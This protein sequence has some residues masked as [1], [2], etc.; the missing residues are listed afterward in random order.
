[1]LDLPRLTCNPPNHP[2]FPYYPPGHSGFKRGL[3]ELATPSN[4]R[5]KDKDQEE[6]DGSVMIEQGDAEEAILIEHDAELYSWIVL[7]PEDIDGDSDD[8]TYG[9]VNSP[10]PSIS[11]SV[12]DLGIPGSTAAAG[13]EGYPVQSQQLHA[14]R[15]LAEDDA[16][17]IELPGSE[18]GSEDESYVVPAASGSPWSMD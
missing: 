7:A 13:F 10:S 17:Y 14:R 8:G 3:F 11:A 16:A 5:V 1:M 18:W 6:S 4:L 15:A 12:E 9:H 2:I